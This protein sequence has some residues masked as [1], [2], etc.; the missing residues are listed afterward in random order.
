MI[1][2]STKQDEDSL[3]EPVVRWKNLVFDK[4]GKSALGKGVW[5]TIE[6]AKEAIRRIESKIND[7]H[8]LLE[9]ETESG[10]LS[11]EDYSWAMQI[12][13]I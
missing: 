5:E 8:I 1:Q 2:E 6:K 3:I 9:I 4:Y 10:M 11:G 13:I 12:P 7:N